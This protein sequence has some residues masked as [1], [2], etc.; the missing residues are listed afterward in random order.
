MNY[1]RQSA[2]WW[3]SE[4]IRFFSKEGMESYTRRA[5][6]AGYNKA[7]LDTQDRARKFSQEI[8][9]D[10]QEVED[11]TI[12]KMDGFED[13][14][15]G[16]CEAFGKQ[17]VLAYSVPAVLEKLMDQGMDEEEAYEFFEFNIAG[18]YVGEGTPCFIFSDAGLITFPHQEH[19]E[20]DK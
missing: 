17:P 2:G 15:L 12:L 8:L 4:G 14:V 1:T 18:A 11:V 3:N 7:L 9:N 13:C 19:K 6:D 16:I 10:L 20:D 5:F